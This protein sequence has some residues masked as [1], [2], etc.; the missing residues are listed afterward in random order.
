MKSKAF[1][2][3]VAFTL[4]V[5]GHTGVVM[6]QDVA[7]DVIA[8]GN[9]S[10]ITNQRIVVI[11]DDAS[12]KAL[13]EEHAGPGYAL[14]APMVNFDKEVVIAH[15]LG[16]TPT[17]AYRVATKDIHSN[18]DYVK[19]KSEVFIP[20][21]L[22]VCLIVEQPFEFIKLPRQTGPFVFKQQPVVGGP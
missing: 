14:N 22:I 20:K 16:T 21:N 10:G 7:F 12:Y 2:F 3:A 1:S 8:S 6:A 9:L 19:V 4:C 17:C 11:S 15:F 5:V 18:A 13:W